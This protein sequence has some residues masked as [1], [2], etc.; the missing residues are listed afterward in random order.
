MGDGPVKRFESYRLKQWARRLRQAGFTL[1]EL[2]M[3]VAVVSLLFALAVPTYG[4]II[5]RTKVSR[6]GQELTKIAQEVQRYRTAH[7]FR[8]PGSLN[9]MAGIPRQDPWGGNYEYLNFSA[10][11]PGIAGLIR[12]DHNLHPLNT[13]FDLYSKGPDG[14]SS[15]ALTSS[16]SR[17][18]VIWARDGSFV[19]KAEDF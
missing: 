13:E 7:D 11:I 12:K 3:A 15:A 6:A 19:G 2:M 18:D 8:L 14:R 10:D 9:D 5:E 17:D 4:R 1:L 16:L